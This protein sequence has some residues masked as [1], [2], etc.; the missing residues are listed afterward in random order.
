MYATKDVKTGLLSPGVYAGIYQQKNY[1]IDNM[2][3]MQSKLISIIGEN[4]SDTGIYVMNL[5]DGPSM[6]INEKK[7]SILQV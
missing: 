6:G 2:V 4:N 3:P 7:S 1:L 5:R